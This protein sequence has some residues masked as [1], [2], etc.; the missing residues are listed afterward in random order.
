MIDDRSN[1]E[2]C[3]DSQNNCSTEAVSVLA[4]GSKNFLVNRVDEEEAGSLGLNC[5]IAIWSAHSHQAYC[6][7]IFDWN[8][9]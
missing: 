1:T 9:Q 7:T 8:M 3:S 6:L 5:L 4:A 2:S